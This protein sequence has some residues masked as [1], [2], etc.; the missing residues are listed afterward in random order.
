[1]FFDDELNIEENCNLKFSTDIGTSKLISIKIDLN[2][3]IKNIVNDFL[4]NIKKLKREKCI[5][6]LNNLCWDE[7]LLKDNV[8][9]KVKSKYIET[10]V[11]EDNILI[12][13]RNK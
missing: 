3:Q 8:H 6:T 9:I 7:I 1:M 11:L 2:Q 5:L 4:F 10:I 13:I 12:D